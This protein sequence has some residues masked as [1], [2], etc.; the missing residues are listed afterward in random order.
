MA[1]IY[2][3]R[4]IPEVG[5]DMLRDAGHTVDISDKDGVL[6]RDELLSALKAKPYDAVLCLLTDSID[7]AVFDVVPTAKIFANY[8]V[9]F[10]NINIADAKARGVMVTNTPGALSDTV[11][12]HA[13]GLILALSC[14]LVEGDRYMRNGSYV[15]WDPMLLLGRDLEGATLG[16]VGAGRIGARVAHI[17]G[18]GFGMKVLYNDVVHNDAVEQGARGVFVDSLDEL[19]QQSDVVSIHVPLLPT[20]HHL[21]NAARLSQMKKT[22][23]LVN[24]S[25][26]PVIDEA[27]LVVALKNGTIAGAGLDVFE[28]EPALAP[29]LVDLPN[30]VLTPHIASA[31]HRARNEMAEIAARNILAVLAGK[32]PENPVP[33]A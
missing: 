28:D 17:A 23:Y 30:V 20:T 26:G 27:A 32:D 1:Q 22:A 18:N 12:E 7:G 33:A 6:T 24:T 15:G 29:G 14:R 10:N 9:G 31:T 19:L 3:T 21:I 25:R 8:A 11:A 13:I 2:V 4:R 5:L 16:L